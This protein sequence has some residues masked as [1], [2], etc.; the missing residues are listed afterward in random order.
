VLSG[1]PDDPSAVM[2]G[3]AGV[4]FGAR[5]PLHDLMPDV[6]LLLPTLVVLAVAAV[7]WRP[8][9][10]VA[11]TALAAGFVLLTA[12]LRWPG[13]SLQQAVDVVSAAFAPALLVARCVGVACL[14]CS[15]VRIVRTTAPF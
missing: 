6:P 13:L 2:A 15:V 10:P 11:L 1:N 3:T 14:L 7:E 12:A 9:R 8:A 4:K 5:R